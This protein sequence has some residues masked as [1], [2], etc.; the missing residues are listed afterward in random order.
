MMIICRHRILPRKYFDF[1]YIRGVVH[2]PKSTFDMASEQLFINRLEDEIYSSIED[3]ILQLAPGVALSQASYQQD[4]TH[5]VH[6]FTGNFTYVQKG[7][8]VEYE[9]ILVGQIFSAEKFRASGVH[10]TGT[11][12]YV[13]Q[14]YL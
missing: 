2:S 10:Y 14:F 9:T 12:A 13:S 5:N 8:N 11:P 3:Q 4:F 1:I 7:T 6:P